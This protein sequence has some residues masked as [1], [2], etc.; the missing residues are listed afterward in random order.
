MKWQRQWHIQHTDTKHDRCTQHTDSLLL[1][2][3]IIIILCMFLPFSIKSIYLYFSVVFASFKNK[4][5][6]KPASNM[7]SICFL[8][9]IRFISFAILVTL[10]NWAHFSFFTHALFQWESISGQIDSQSIRIF[11]S[12]SFTV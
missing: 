8:L 5:L 1:F 4:K 10:T 11:V 12:V 9:P 6:K 7:H 3:I 2:I